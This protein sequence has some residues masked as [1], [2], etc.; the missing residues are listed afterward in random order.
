MKNFEYTSTLKNQHIIFSFA[1]TNEMD[2]VDILV[3]QIHI[4]INIFRKRAHIKGIF[5]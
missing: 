3:I 5:N 4:R 2:G 1:V